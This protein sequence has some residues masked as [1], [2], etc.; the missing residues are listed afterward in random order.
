MLGLVNLDF[1]IN[2]LKNCVSKFGDERKGRNKQY[3][4][5]EIG[6]AAYSV[7]HMQSPSFLAHQQNMKKRK[8]Q[9][10]GKTLFGFETIP[11]DNHI[12]QQLDPVSPDS[13]AP[14]FEEVTRSLNKEE[15]SIDGRFLMAI[16][17]VTFFSSPKIHCSCCLRKESAQGHVTYS[18]AALCPVIVHPILQQVIP[19][20][21][22]FIQNEDGKEKQDCELNAAKRWITQNE[23]FLKEHKV[24]LLGDD[25]FSR[26]PLVKMID[27][28]DGVDYIFVA[29]PGSHTHMYQWID[30]MKAQDKTASTVS[31]KA[32]ASHVHNYVF[33]NQVPL[34]GSETSPS[35][36]YFDMKVAN[37]KGAQLYHNTFVT[38]LY[39]TPESIHKIACM[40]RNRWRIENEAFNVLKTKGYHLQHNFGHGSK[41][42]ANLFATFNLVAFAIH[43][44]WK[45]A[46]EMFNKMW[47][48]FSS[49]K[50]FF[51]SLTTLTLFHLFQSWEHLLDFVKDGLEET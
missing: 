49:R 35:V 9:H 44:L 6:M 38:S 50:Q 36:A 12:R 46:H 10:N 40:G 27:K 43:T 28:L 32:F 37:K 23:E 4:M 51:Q 21:P 16:D 13:L 25:L 47:N 41:N 1:Y 48:A 8:G 26:E 24:I 42:L 18:H 45:L 7:F 11:S 22:M 34:N 30:G 31:D 5:E 20:L 2:A 15:W 17:G 33:A 3:T 39:L 14:F 19:L 29:K